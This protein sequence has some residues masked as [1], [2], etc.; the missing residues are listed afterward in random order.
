M[1]YAK[2]QPKEFKNYIR[3]VAIV[4][5]GG[6]IGKFIVD[7]ILANKK[8]VVT[9]ITRKES[10]TMFPQG[11]TVKQIDYEDQASI[12]SA[13]QG[14]DALVITM[15]VAAPAGQNAKL[16]EAAAEAGVPWIIPDEYGNDL[17]IESLSKDSMLAAA[18]K[19][20]RDLI[21]RLGKSSWV[22]VACNFWYEFSLG[23][24]YGFDFK[25]KSV[26]F[27]DDGEE[28]IPTATWSLTGKTVASLLSLKVLP[29]NETDT[30]VTLDRYRNKYVNVKSFQISQKE[31]FASILRVTGDRIEDWDI[32]SIK[33]EDCYFENLQKLQQGDRLA[34]VRVLYS[35]FFFKGTSAAI[36]KFDN[37]E[38]GLPVE[39]LDTSTRF[40][41]DLHLDGYL[42]K[43][44]SMNL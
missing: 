24:G 17:S 33:A 3:N 34:F 30:D 10:T 21:E 15:N 12:I 42:E 14:Q 26:L 13:L 16:I 32:K 7:A 44:Y 31:M 25:N 22:G 1:K 9:A 29:N 37:T 23:G 6:Q 20:D 5:A 28:K 39:D 27:Y 40:A 2:D 4:G 38:L 35:G 19:A 18:K 36:T 8:Q 41:I 43:R 11:V